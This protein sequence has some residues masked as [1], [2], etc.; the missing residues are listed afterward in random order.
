MQFAS[1]DWCDQ[2]TG[3]SLACPAE[4]G[5]YCAAVEWNELDAPETPGGLEVLSQVGI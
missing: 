2:Q 1:L 4:G 3:S 5:S